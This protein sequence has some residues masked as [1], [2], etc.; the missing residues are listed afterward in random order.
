M[1]AK[2]YIPSKDAVFDGWFKFMNQYVAQKCGGSTP[3]WTHIPQAARTVLTDAYAAWYTAYVNTIGPHTPVDTEA[4]NDDKKAA[5]ALIR[6]FVN[7]YLRFP[8]VTDED[9]TAMGIPNRD[10]KPTPVPKPG[11][12]P[13]VAVRTPKPRVLQFPFR[14]E[15]MKRWGKPGNVHGLEL[16][17][18]FAGEPPENLERQGHSE[19]STKS[20]LELVFEEPERGKKFYFIVRWETNAMKKGDWSEIYSAI[21]P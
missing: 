5:K 20:P 17:W 15:G 12:I 2:D 18:L 7:Q 3:A 16:K 8:P 6:P 13:E 21:V 9:R 10:R 19:F 1:M 14:R 11:D 4:K